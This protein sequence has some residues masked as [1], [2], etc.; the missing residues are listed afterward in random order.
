MAARILVPDGR[1]LTVAAV[2]GDSLAVVLAAQLVHADSPAWL[3]V[4]AGALPGGA[5]CRS[6]WRLSPWPPGPGRLAAVT[7]QRGADRRT[8]TLLGMTAFATLVALGVVAAQAIR[9]LDPD[10]AVTFSDVAI[11]LQRLSALIAMTAVP[12]LA[13]GLTVMRGS[14]RDKELAAYHLAGTIV[15]LVAMFVMLAALALAW[16]AP[17]WLI[18]VAVLNAVVSGLCGIPLASAGPA[19]G[20][21]ACAALAY[22]TA[23]YLLIGE[24]PIAARTRTA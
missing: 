5:V 24:L 18:A 2:L 22:L 12:L 7:A 16:P 1:W 21:I 19:R 23:F 4:G 14:G 15:A 20:A 11:V 17:G 10:Q 13:G 6:G 9:P 3:M 8:V